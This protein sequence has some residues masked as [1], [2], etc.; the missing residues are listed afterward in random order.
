MLM[1]S[2]LQEIVRESWT[3]L[4]RSRV[5]TLLTMLGIVWGIVAVTLLIAY[6]FCALVNLLPMP[7]YFAGLLPT[8][9]SGILAFA[10]L[11]TVALLSSVYPAQRA[12]SVDPIEALRFEAGG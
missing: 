7:M 4:A 2:M 11:G 12:A 10:L 9:S 6:G 3:A 1:L 5:R 8:W